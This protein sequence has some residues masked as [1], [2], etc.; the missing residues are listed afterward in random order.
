M[1]DKVVLNHW[2]HE[3]L[4]GLGLGTNWVEYITLGIDIILVLLLSLVVDFIARKVI[5]R[6]VTR[7]VKRSKNQYDDILLE[8]RVFRSLAHIMP[9]LVIYYSL[10]YLF[11][12]SV[13][14]IQFL[15]KLVVTYMIINIINV[16]HKFLKALEHIG[17][18]SP[19]FE[20]KPVSS[21]I[22]VA[23]ICMYI[24]GGVFILSNLVDKSATA[25][26]TTFGAATAVILLI[27]RDTILGLVASIQ[28]SGNDMVR[29]G[30]WVSMPKYGADGDVTEINLTTVKVRNW[31][32]TISTVPT[33]AFISDSFVNWRGMT[34]QGVRRI[35][36]SLNIDIHSIK[37]VDDELYKK[38][39]KVE[40]IKTYLEKRHEEIRLSNESKKVDK[41]VLVN[42]R[43]L[44]NIGVFRIYMESYLAEHPSIAQ[45]Q[46]LMVRQLQ[47]TELGVPLEIYCFSNDIAWLNYEQIQSNI[48]DHLMAA[49]DHFELHIF[50]NPSG[51]DFRG[52]RG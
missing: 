10:P 29:I 38:L 24:A 19:R 28:I 52:L 49:V 9:A 50:Q 35:K 26:L 6:I 25:I 40:R 15:Q 11:D 5:L 37:F 47:P 27:F 51:S 8:K 30:D 3:W 45:D 17:L 12:E 42:G 21:Y 46:T 43:H 41:S 32:K 20:G 1:N 23:M 33:Y 2:A 34:S 14:L 36:R 44:T 18:S 48:M 16:G 31:D 13:G 4:A 7:Y 22:Q 39:L